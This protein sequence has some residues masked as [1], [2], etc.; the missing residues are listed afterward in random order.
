[1][2]KTPTK[3]LQLPLILAEN[4]IFCA[5]GKARYAH[6]VG[7]NADETYKDPAGF[8]QSRNNIFTLTLG[9]RGGLKR[10]YQK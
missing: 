10:H 7:G 8:G 2:M 5:A 3:V 4:N 1:M 6:G 9:G